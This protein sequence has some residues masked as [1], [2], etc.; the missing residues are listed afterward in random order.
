MKENAVHLSFP[1]PESLQDRG[2]YAL[3]FLG[4]ITSF[5]VLSGESLETRRVFMVAIK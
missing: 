3:Q 4:S 1:T 2:R 5:I